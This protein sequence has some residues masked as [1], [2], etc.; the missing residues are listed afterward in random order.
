MSKT[1]DGWKWLG[2][3]VAAAL[4]GY[5]GWANRRM[6]MVHD[7]TTGDS[8]AYPKLRSRV[9]YA[10][11]APAMAA[12]EQALA[13]LP[14]WTLKS[15]DAQNDIL[16]AQAQTPPGLFT[17]DVTLYFFALGHGQ[18]RVTLRARAR[19]GV[20]DLGRNAAHIR[21]MQAAMDARLNTGAA[22]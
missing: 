3:A 9:Y 19:L 13:R 2:G 12:A 4:A 22:F 16:E 21:Q 20:G 11:V 6:F 14:G 15:R 1:K 10:E 18:T 7:V 5:A 17:D 8:A